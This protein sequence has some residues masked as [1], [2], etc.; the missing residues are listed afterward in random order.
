MIIRFNITSTCFLNS[1]KPL[2]NKFLKYPHKSEF[3]PPRRFAYSYV[4]L[5][6][7]LSKP[8]FPPGEIPKI[9]PKSI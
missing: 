9:N 2:T 6:G 3:F 1:I 8:T 5:N 4:N 7:A